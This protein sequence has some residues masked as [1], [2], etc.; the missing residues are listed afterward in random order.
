[1]AQADFDEDG[2][3][4]EAQ[5]QGQITNRKFPAKAVIAPSSDIRQTFH[6]TFETEAQMIEAQRQRYEIIE[7]VD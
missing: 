1:M 4:R 5:A 6:I 2:L 7:W 3:F